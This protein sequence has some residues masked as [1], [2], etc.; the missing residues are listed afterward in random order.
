M[1]PLRFQLPDGRHIK[2]GPERYEA[3]ECLFQPELVDVEQPGMAEMLFNVIQAS[4]VD[5]RT[6]L[7]KHVVLSG[8]S[9][10]YPGLPSRLEKEM[11]Q[12]YLTRVLGGNPERLNA[13][14]TFSIIRTRLRCALTYAPILQKFKVGVD[15]H[16]G[17][18]NLVFVGGAV[19]ADIMAN[20][21]AY[22]VTKQEWEEQGVRALDKLSPRTA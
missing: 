2:V 12:L 19:L 7:Y 6:E 3:P 18:K 22:W 16:P 10:M 11:K 8:G 9:S 17:R 15:A 4:P 20:N 14:Q 5:V 13:R 21:P 1:T